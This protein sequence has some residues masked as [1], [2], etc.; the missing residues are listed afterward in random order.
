MWTFASIAAHLLPH[1]ALLLQSN[2]GVG[3]AAGIAKFV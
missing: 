1:W 3:L 2:A